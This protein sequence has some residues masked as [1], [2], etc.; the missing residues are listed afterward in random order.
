MFNKNGLNYRQPWLALSKTALMDF[1]LVAS[2]FSHQT[3]QR[4]EKLRLCYTYKAAKS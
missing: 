3:N 2:N 1:V 4:H